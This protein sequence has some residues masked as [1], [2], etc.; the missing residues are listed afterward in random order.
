MM[1]SSNAKSRPLKKV[2]LFI[3]RKGQAISGGWR[4]VVKDKKPGETFENY[5]FNV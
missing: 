4:L 3:E 5:A 2:F 1:I